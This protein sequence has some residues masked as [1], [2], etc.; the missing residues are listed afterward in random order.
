MRLLRP[1]HYLLAVIGV[2]AGFTGVQL[3]ADLSP[4]DTIAAVRSRLGGDSQADYAADYSVD[5]FPAANAG[6]MEALRA[7]PRE[8]RATTGADLM[9][10]LGVHRLADTNSISYSIATTDSTEGVV[11][12]QGTFESYDGVEVPFYE[13]R[14]PGFTE[15]RRQAAVVLFS[16]HGRMDQLAFDRRSYQKGAGL[17]LARQG[18]L[19]FVM[20]NRGMG[21]LS[22][23][24]DH[25]RIDAVARMLGGSW[26]GEVI[27]DGLL[28]LDFVLQRPYVNGRVG[29]GGVSSGGAL[30]LMTA[31]I[32][33]RVTSAYVQGYFGSY[34]TTFGT[35]ANHDLCN[36]IP[37]ILRHFDMSDIAL[38]IF[39]RPVLFVNGKRDKFYYGDAVEAFEPV[40][41]RY[42]AGGVA[43]LASIATPEDVKHEFSV[44]LARAFFARTLD[45]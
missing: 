32:D 2:M 14:P 30:S 36:N 24:G 38:L 9:R 43:D 34:R 18:F 31:A 8:P 3:Y 7:V 29:V 23:L 16:G 42:A 1:T 10:V 19:V 27:T 39:P 12:R 40:E 6:L 26:Y 44:E 15:G 13:L 20:E 22:Y 21:T 37:A 41:A 45:R 4:Q 17:D 5:L 11:H 28:F 33:G 35:R 25:L